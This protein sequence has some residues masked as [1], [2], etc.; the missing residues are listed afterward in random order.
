MITV[1]GQKVWRTFGL[2]T[3]QVGSPKLPSPVV[4]SHGFG[5]ICPGAEL[6]VPEISTAIPIQWS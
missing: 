2:L 5:F 3:E 4:S 1:A 6:L